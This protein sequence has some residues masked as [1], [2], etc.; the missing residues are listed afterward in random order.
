[1]TCGRRASS[2]SAA[3]PLRP[4]VLHTH[5][6][7][8]G[9]LGRVVGRLRTCRWWS[10]PATGCGPR[11]TDR[12]RA[13][14]RV[15]RRGRGL[16]VQPRRAVPERHRPADARALVRRGK[17]R[18]GRQR[19][20]PRPRF[21]HSVRH[22]TTPAAHS[23]D[24]RKRPADWAR[25]HGSRRRRRA[26]GRR[27]GHPASSSTAAQLPAATA[28][29]SSSCWVGPDDPDKPDACGAVTASV[30][31]L[32]ERSDMP[33]VYNALDVFVLPSYRE[34]FSRSAMEAAAC[35]H[36]H[37]ADRHPRLPRGRRRRPHLLLVPPRDADALTGRS[38]RLVDDLSLR[39]RLAGAAEQRA[40][41]G[42]RPA[43]D[44]RADPWRP[45][46]TWRAGAV[47]AG[48]R[49]GR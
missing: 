40:P 10:T 28:T 1:M 17:S 33:A 21:R 23:L 41:D 48:R 27:E 2:W 6:P 47:S 3:A 12:L 35:R 39:Q 5:N 14:A 42:V 30:R 49:C 26:H 9:V 20:R 13:A 32:G 16:G 34:G 22:G 38:A 46:P 24:D 19:H 36:R 8:T 44:R 7:K 29:A 37:G 43:P 31:F 15:R 4:D 45:T 11:P 18:G 25:G